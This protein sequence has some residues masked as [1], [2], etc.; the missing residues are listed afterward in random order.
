MVANAGCGRVILP[1]VSPWSTLPSCTGR[2][3]GR[4]REAVG[5]LPATVPVKL[6]GFRKICGPRE[7]RPAPNV[8]R[9]TA[10]RVV[11]DLIRA[12]IVPISIKVQLQ[13]ILP[14]PHL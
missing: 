7:P 11:K 4:R 14:F 10:V 9:K 8:P 1:A 13:A 6:Y 2:P 3:D 12:C 5:R